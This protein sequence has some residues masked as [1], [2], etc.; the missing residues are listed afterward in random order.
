MPAAAA[1]WVHTCH[2]RMHMHMNMCMHMCMH[3]HMHRHSSLTLT[4]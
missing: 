2:M 1:A 4:K 3:M